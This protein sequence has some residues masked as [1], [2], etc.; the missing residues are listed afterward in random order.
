MSALYDYQEPFSAE[1]R[2]F[3][4]LQETGYEELAVPCFGYAL[5]DEEHERAMMAQCDLNYWSFNG[6]IDFAGCV[7]EEADQRRRFLGK[8]GRPPPLRCIVKAFGEVIPQDDEGRFQQTTARRLLQD[9]IKLQKL[10]IMQIDVGTRQL[11]DGKYGDFSTA[12]TMPHFITSPEL[13]PNLT[14]AMI[15]QMQKQTF[16]HC[17]NDYLDFDAMVDA[18]NHEFGEVKGHMSVEAYPGGRGIGRS[19]PHHLRSER[20]KGSEKPLYTFVDPRRYG[21]NTSPAGKQSGPSKEKGS[22]RV[23]KKVKHPA[24]QR[25]DLQSRL[26]KLSARPDIWRWDSEEKDAE[27]ADDTWWA[28]TTIGHYIQWSYKDGYIYPL[29]ST[30]KDLA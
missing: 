13:N 26:Q 25:K 9:L 11:V 27:W 1:C 3:G 23:S 24:R 18:W 7:D 4:R 14:P 19:M 28:M 29:S 17:V 21:W 2:A 10:G 22:G 20:G 12:I 5:L 30:G 6:D 8:D 16:E 15:D